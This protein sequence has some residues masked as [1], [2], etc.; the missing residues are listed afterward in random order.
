MK[1][2]LKKKSTSEIALRKALYWLD[3][4]CM[5]TLTESDNEWLI[6]V[7]CDENLKELYIS[8]IHKLVND[9]TLRERIS[10]KTD[11]LKNAI[12]KKTL[13]DLTT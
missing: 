13:K 12:I 3:D 8:K 7:S 11:S 9:Y 5:W 4:D 2:L 6:E 10:S 1:I